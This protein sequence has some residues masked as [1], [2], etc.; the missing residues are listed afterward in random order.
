MSGHR[1]L[2]FD[3]QVRTPGGQSDPGATSKAEQT[4]GRVDG[5]SSR[6]P[7]DHLPGARL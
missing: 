1:S 2:A 5:M 6:D 7:T 4:V 3:S